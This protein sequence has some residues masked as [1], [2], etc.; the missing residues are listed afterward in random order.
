MP[1][2]KINLKPFLMLM[3]AKHEAKE[4]KEAKSHEKKEGSKKGPCA[5]KG[6]R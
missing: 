1:K 4:A 2:E 6:K 5:P 3:A